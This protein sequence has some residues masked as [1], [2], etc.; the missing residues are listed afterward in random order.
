MKS[1][2][3]FLVVMVLVLTNVTSLF[4]NPKTNL[5]SKTITVC[6]VE[7]TRVGKGANFHFYYLY[8]IFTDKDGSVEKISR[9]DKRPE[10]VR[11]DKIIEC[12]QTWKL[13]PSSRYSVILSVGTTSTPN[14][15]SIVDS[16]TEPIKLLLT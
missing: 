16:K 9:L 13:E 14:S 3:K 4:A 5:R 8:L 10:F 1:V 2:S 11:Q 7:L 15:I 6:P 12:M